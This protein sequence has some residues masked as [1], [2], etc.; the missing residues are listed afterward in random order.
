[1]DLPDPVFRDLK[2]KAARDG[3]TL[4]E[5]LTSFVEE[6]LY[7]TSAER[8]TVAKSP[9]PVFFEPTGE[10]IPALTN[11]ELEEIFTTEDFGRGQ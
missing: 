3:V 8:K 6:G 1:M 11:A 2:T 10:T 9:L 4:K 7:G 5:L